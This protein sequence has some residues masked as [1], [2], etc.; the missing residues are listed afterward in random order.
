[1]YNLRN[2]FASLFNSAHIKMTIILMVA[3]G[4]LIIGSQITGTTDNLP[5]LSMLF[6]GAILFFFSL[7]HPW[8]KTKNYVIFLLVCLAI[9]ILIFAGIYILAALHLDK[10]ISEAFVMITILL[11]CLPGIFASIL[12]IIY[13]STRKQ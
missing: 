1:M 4:L 13:C 6:T 7:L 3:A 10:Y 9:I 11:F 8:R 12:G 5:G 2:H